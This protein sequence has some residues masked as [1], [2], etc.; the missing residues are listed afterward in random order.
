MQLD[1]C[2]L[3]DTSSSTMICTIHIDMMYNFFI[4][5]IHDFSHWNNSF[6]TEI[7]QSGL[8]SVSLNRISSNNHLN[9]VDVCF[10]LK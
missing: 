8:S 10:S 7:Y 3:T 5:S 6:H 9:K 4:L 1:H 2:F